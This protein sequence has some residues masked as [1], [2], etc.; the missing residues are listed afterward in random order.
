[1]KLRDVWRVANN[2]QS[3]PLWADVL[4]Y[5]ATSSIGAFAAFA[6]SYLFNPD[7]DFDWYDFLSVMTGST[8]AYVFLS[9]RRRRLKAELIAGLNPKK[10]E[11]VSFIPEKDSPPVIHGT[12]FRS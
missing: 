3:L 10:E 12:S 5:I 1:M 9:L 4:V 11:A 7:S 6:L 2:S 8:I